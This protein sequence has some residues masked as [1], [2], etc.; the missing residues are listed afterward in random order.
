MS[1]RRSMVFSKI[2][3]LLKRISRRFFCHH[4]LAS[5]KPNP[6]DGYLTGSA[7]ACQKLNQTTYTDDHRVKTFSKASPDCACEKHRTSPFSPGVIDDNEFVTRFV[8]SPVHLNKAKN[9]I[10]SSVFSHVHHKGCSI[11]RESIVSDNELTN[12]VENFKKMNPQLTWYGILT[13][14]CAELRGIQIT[15]QSKRAICLY[16]MAEHDNPAHGE[17]HQTEYVI[18]D[19]DQVELRAKLFEIFNQGV[20]TPPNNY[21]SGRIALGANQSAV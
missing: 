2:F 3:S 9:K 14:R 12:F 13:A 19:A 7:C 5:S 4:S 1:L 15:G 17:M 11:Q 16:D 20:H 10:K 18:E 21:R 6:A 8:F